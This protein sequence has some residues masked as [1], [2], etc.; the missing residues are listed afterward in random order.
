M[1][2]ISI[3]LFILFIS[4]IL[5]SQS[6][7]RRGY[8][9]SQSRDTIFGL[10]N[11][12]DVK[13]QHQYCQIKELQQVI[14]Y[15]PDKV[16]GYGFIN[17]SYFESRKIENENNTSEPAFLEVLIKGLVSLYKYE[18]IFYIE[19]ADSKLYKLSNELVTY[20]VDGRETARNSGRYIGFLNLLLSDCS[21]INSKIF[22]TDFKEKSLFNLIEQYNKCMN[23]PVTIYKSQKPWVY[24]KIGISGGM[25]ISQIAITTLYTDFY[26]LTD[27]FDK[28]KSP[29]FSISFDMSAPRILERFSLHGDLVLHKLTGSYFFEETVIY[30]HTTRDYIDVDITQLSLPL[31]IRYSLPVGKMTLFMNFGFQSTLNLNSDVNWKQEIET[32]MGVETDN[33]RFLEVRKTQ[34]G[35]WGGTGLA[36]SISKNLNIFIDF[37]YE[38]VTGINSEYLLPTTLSNVTGYQFSL[39]ISTK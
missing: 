19:K 12:G 25:N 34:F 18:T 6:D 29:A 21:E 1:K 32:F 28:S 5:Y 38:K 22:S 26:H 36:K 39:G 13:N 3:I 20:T 27:S 9:I 30:T 24:F 8:I 17:G 31:G 33:L 15:T 10:I 35:L 14:K 4:K 23:A 7:Y 11:Y 16:A 37:R 2:R